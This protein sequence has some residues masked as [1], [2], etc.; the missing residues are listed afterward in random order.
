MI[1]SQRTGK[2]TTFF[3]LKTV[4]ICF[5]LSITVY[6]A[7]AQAPKSKKDNAQAEQ[8]SFKQRWGIK[9]NAVD[10]LLTVPNVGVEFDLGNTIRTKHTLNANLKWNWNTSHDYTPPI[11]F[12]LFDARVEWRQYFRTRK[13]GGTTKD[14]NLLKRLSETVFTTQRKNPRTNRA[15]YWGVYAN[16]ASY[17]FKI[18][19]EGKQGTAYGAGLSLGYTA[20]LYGYKKGNIDLEMGGAIGLLYTSYDTYKHDAES[21]CYPVVSSKGGHIVPFPVITDLRVAFVYRFMS[22]GDKYKASVYRRVQLRD[23][24][25]QAVNEKINKMRERID[26]ISNAVRKQGFSRPDSLLNKEELKLWKQMQQERKE[27]VEKEAADKLRKQV[28]DSLGIQLSDTLTSAQEKAIRKALK[29]REEQLKR[30]AEPQDS[31]KLAKRAA[32]EEAKAAKEAE[33]AARKAGK[34]AEETDKAAEGADNVTQEA[35]KAA[36]SPKEKE[37]KKSKKGRK[38]KKKNEE[39]KKEEEGNKNSAEEGNENDAG[40][41][42]EP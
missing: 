14:A 7:N 5:L 10:W 40:K 27:Q 29:E 6:Q 1:F 42:E 19:K 12:N 21:D 36:K 37:E 3:L 15:Y 24:A 20:P 39:G 33:K 31:V 23:F 30:A 8:I 25:R 26:S 9:T 16:A 28:A 13:R 17:N 2:S 4:V 32:K 22:V 34:V 41:E 18:G 11:L 35:E 38:T